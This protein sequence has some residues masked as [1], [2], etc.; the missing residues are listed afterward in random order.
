MAIDLGE[1][2]KLPVRDYWKHEEHE[3][4]PWLAQDE[5]ISRLAEAIAL[6]LQVERVEVPVGPFSADVLAKDASG[7]YVVIENQFGKTNHDHLGK[8]L[9]YAANLGATAVV[10]LAEQFTDEHRKTIEW[11]NEHVSDELSL[12]A[13]EIELWQIDT[14]RPAVRFN[15][16][17]QP[18]EISKQATAVK[19]AGPL[20][21]VK[22]LQ[23]DFWT[24]FRSQLLEKKI[25]PT[26]ET[27]RPQYWFHVPLGRAN[28]YLSNI[29]NTEAGRIGVRVYINNKIASAALPQLEAERAE[30]ETEI[31]EKLEWNPNPEAI[32]KTIVL[33]RDA[34]LNDRNQ[35]PEYVSW[36]VEKVD[37]FRKAFVPRV[38]KLNLD[39]A[40]VVT[41]A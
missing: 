4:T 17:S 32:D 11:L 24:A 13:V 35:W 38:K 5:N 8:L 10:W 19:S 34:D 20:S 27:P 25:V 37:K 22:K 16:L 12:Y 23:L 14:S 30:I 31:G 26:A 36:L 18:T 29:A 40:P 15:V 33:Q 21:E 28:I 41:S 9:T 6:E 39:Q 1:I 7:N 3:F 2:R